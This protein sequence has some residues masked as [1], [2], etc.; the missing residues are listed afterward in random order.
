MFPDLN[1][2]PH[3][4]RLRASCKE[5][6][7]ALKDVVLVLNDAVIIINV[8]EPCVSAIGD[9]VSLTL[10]TNGL[11]KFIEPFVRFLNET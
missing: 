1:P 3:L 10:L 5:H 7:S 6:L 9:K 4:N 11:L 8:T 2:L